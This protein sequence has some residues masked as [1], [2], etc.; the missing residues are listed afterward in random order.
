MNRNLIFL[1]IILLRYSHMP[2]KSRTKKKEFIFFGNT[3]D[4]LHFNQIFNKLKKNKKY[5]INILNFFN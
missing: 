2:K 4:F 1:V 5:L 3:I